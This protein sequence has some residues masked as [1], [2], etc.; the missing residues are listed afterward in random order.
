MKKKIIT[1]ILRA[2]KIRSACPYVCK[3]DH[4]QVKKYLFKK[5]VF[6]HSLNWKKLVILINDLAYRKSEYL[7]IK[8]FHDNSR[9]CIHN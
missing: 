1:L 2:A 3:L 4:F 8:K 5:T 9:G 7:I 6:T